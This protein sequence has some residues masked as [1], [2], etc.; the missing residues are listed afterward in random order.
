MSKINV[1]DKLNMDMSLDGYIYWRD[2]IEFCKKN[3]YYISK[4]FKIINIYKEISKKHEITAMAAERCMRYARERIIDLNKKMKVDYSINNS[5][6]LA[7]IIREETK[8]ERLD[9]KC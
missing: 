5:N 4:T 2:A 3:N 1:L 6:F 8:N 7:W 9:R